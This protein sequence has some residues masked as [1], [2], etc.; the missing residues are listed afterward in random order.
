MINNITAGPGIVVSGNHSTNPYISMTN[1]SAGLVRYNGNTQGVEVYDGSSWQRLDTGYPQVSL[2]PD[3]ERLVQWAREKREEEL[4]FKDL[5]SRHPG[6][7]NLHDQLE[8]MKALCAKE[9]EQEE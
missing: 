4:K 3:V 6:L 7:K 1:P 9:Q 8:M 5:M 2:A